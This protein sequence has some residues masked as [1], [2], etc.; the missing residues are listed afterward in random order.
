MNNRE[1]KKKY[2]YLIN[3]AECANGRKEV[4]G[5]LKKAAKLKSKIEINNFVVK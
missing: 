2:S 3:K 4:V 1:I 5:L